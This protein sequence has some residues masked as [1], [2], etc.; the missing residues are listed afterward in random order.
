[1]GIVVK[2]VLLGAVAV[3]LLLAGA[4]AGAAALWVDAA[5]GSEGRITIDAGTITPAPLSQAT[6]FDVDRFG[7]TVP[8]IGAF[9]NTTL[10][11]SSGERGDPS[12]TLFIGAGPT[13]D[14]DA[15]LKGSTYTVAIRQ[16][17]EW[18]TRE[19]PGVTSAPLP[20]EQGFWLAD[21]VGPRPSVAVPDQRPV[22]VV[23]MHP[24]GLPSGPLVVGIDFT[25]PDA[26]SW[27]RWLAIACAV[28]LLLGLVL[29]IT[30]IRMN[31]GPGRHSG[32]AA[33]TGKHA[34]H[35]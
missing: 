31:R 32:G 3:L 8:V 25:V 5:L 2:K 13:A 7:A 27:V 10:A 24:A 14:V 9:G 19:V 23:L 33:T 28:L 30:A 1:M 21:D 12:D 16:G 35:G 34:A 20:G 15:Y 4:A 22:T 26:G 18:T 6:V 17:D 11:V 29:L